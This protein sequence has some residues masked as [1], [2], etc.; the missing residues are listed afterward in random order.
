[1]TI[2]ASALDGD[3][4][5]IA[6]GLLGMRLRSEAGGAVTEVVITE[7][8]AYVGDLDPASHAYRGRTRRNGSMFESPGTLYVYR[9]YGLHWCL[10]IVVGPVGVPHAV[11]VR[12]GVPSVGEEVMVRR[13]GR[14]DHLTDGPGKLAPALAIT[15]DHDGTS[16][17]G[18]V[19]TGPLTLSAGPGPS[20]PVLAT[21]RIGISKA[22]DRPW[23]FVTTG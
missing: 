13:R 18:G 15:G 11:L 21:P 2:P 22:V 5:D 12:A 4:L 3:V 6:P 19:R 8:E 17:L 14:A 10:N 20:G 16:V 7:V 9:S 23:R 1:M